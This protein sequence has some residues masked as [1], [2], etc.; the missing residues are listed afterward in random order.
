MSTGLII[1]L[2][3]AALAIGAI[4]A[5]AVLRSRRS[6]ELRRT[7]GP[8]YYR[9]VQATGKRSEAERELEHR[10]ERVRQLEV[11]PLPP[12]E[13]DRFA[14]EWQGVQKRFV[15]SPVEAVGEA[16]RLVTDVMQRRGYPMADF[17][18]RSADLSVDHP[19][20][21]ENY[22]SAHALAARAREGRASTED[23]RQAMV[24]YRTLFADLL[25][26]GPPKTEVKVERA[27]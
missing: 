26:E 1:I 9:T 17:E 4:A 12:S 16:D 10:Q 11:R 5:W 6:G 14:R 2:V 23:L 25:E 24:H 13:V 20:V 15:D 18:Q 7:F 8:E 27:S 3:L 22:R 19:Q 21:V